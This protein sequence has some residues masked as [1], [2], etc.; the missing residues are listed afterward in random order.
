MS[1]QK[2]QHDN[3]GSMETLFKVLR[4]IGRYR[5]LLILSILLAAVSVILQ[6]Y[7]PILFGNAIDQVVAEHQ[8]N[9]A[10]MW[11]YLSRILIMVIVSSVATW[12]M[13][14]IPDSSG[15]SCKSD[16]TY[17]GV[18]SFLPGQPQ[19]RRYYQPYHC[20]YRY[21]F[22][23]SASRIYTAFFWYRYYYRDF[24]LHVFQE[25]LDHSDGHCTDSGKFL[26][27]QV[28]FFQIFPDVPQ[29]E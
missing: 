29:A 23:W 8:V 4:F 18:A 2:K 24:D 15:Y 9:F 13:N 21:P 20:R 14:I 25:L 5:F 11:Y 22:G 12:V 28:Y 6:L 16:T 3:A 27:G 1:K 26:C 10:D 17:T 7:V 19:H